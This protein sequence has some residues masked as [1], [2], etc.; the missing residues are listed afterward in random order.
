MAGALLPFT[1]P[2]HAEPAR[3]PV[4][5]TFSILGDFV[6][7]VGG[8]SVDVS[9]VVGPDG[10][11]HVYEPTPADAKK[12]AAAKLIVVNG[13]GF[14]GWLDRLIAASG[15]KAQIV[16]ASD[17]VTPRRLE[18]ATDPHA[19]QDVANARRYVENIRDALKKA[20]PDSERLYDASA[21]IYLEELALLDTVVAR[22][23]DAIPSARRRV[24]STHD[25]FGYFAARYGLEFIAP[26]GVS[27]DAEASARDIA[28]IIDAAKRE[29]VGAVFLENV[30]DPRLA[31]RL[32][33]EAGVKLGGVL[34]SDALSPPDGPAPTYVRMMLHN[35]EELTKALKN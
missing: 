1:A 8:A 13:L 6:R 27:T 33:A 12:L 24:V 9:V 5:A 34:Y 26:Q 22:K 11:A 14:E 18:G 17:G 4:V 28:Q 30:V 21:T 15:T 2:A 31:T 25:A 3:L 29:K 16:V 19:W 35:V 20:D 10:D 7:E 32:A 23:V